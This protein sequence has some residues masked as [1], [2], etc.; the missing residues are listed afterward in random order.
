[1]TLT[2]T[3]V[4]P[5]SAAEWDAAWKADPAATY[6]MSR[7]WAELWS[8]ISSGTLA[9]AASLVSFS[10]GQ[11]GVLPLV[12]SRQYKGLLH[13]WQ[14]CAAGG[15]GAPLSAAQFTADHHRLLLAQLLSLRD[16]SW[17]TSPIDDASAVYAIDGAELQ[18]THLLSLHGPMTE[19]LKRWSKGARA[20]TKQ[21][22]RAGVSVRQANTAQDWRSYFDVYQDSLRRWG[23]R[24][25]SNHPWAVFERLSG[26]D[27]GHVRLWLAELDGRVIAGALCLYAQRHVSYWHGAALEAHFDA[28]PVNALML[29]AIEHAVAAGYRWFDFGLSGGHEGVAAFK[30][31]FGAEAVPCHVVSRQSASS[32]LIKRVLSKVLGG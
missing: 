31:G 29:T 27:A 26:A 3:A 23:D 9:P 1:M 12:V 28:R 24:A 8:S 22:R 6:S 20:A 21:A 32:R 2:I 25:T 17:M 16:V 4:R 19:I 30:R 7:E 13:G 5:A 11:R 18:H 14:A 15:Y 10:D